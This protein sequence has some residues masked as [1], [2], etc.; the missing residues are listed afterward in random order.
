MLLLHN[1]EQNQHQ[2][3]PEYHPKILSVDQAVSRE[4]IRHPKN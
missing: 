1:L 2:P 3:N 4:W